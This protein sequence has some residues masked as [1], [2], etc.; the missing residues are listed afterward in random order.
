MVFPGERPLTRLGALCRDDR[1]VIM[2]MVALLLP[3]ILGFVGLGYEVGLWYQTKRSLQNSADAGA[4]AGAYE[5][6]AGG[7]LAAIRLASK[8]EAERDGYFDTADG[9]VI[10][11]TNPYNS[12]DYQVEVELSNQV[13]LLFSSFFM[14]SAV[15]INARAVAEVQVGDQEA[16]VLALNGGIRSSLAASGGI[17]VTM[18]GCSLAANSDFDPS[19]SASG[20][21]TITADCFY[22]PG[23]F[24]ESGGGTLDTTVCDSPQAGITIDDPYADM[25]EPT[26]A[27]CDADHTNYRL[28]AGGVE[29]IDPG[30]WCGGIDITGGS[31]LTM[32]PGLYILNEGHFSFSGGSSITAVG[33]S[34]VLMDSDG[35]NCGDIDFTGGSNVNMSAMTS[36]DFEGF[37]FYRHSSCRSTGGDQIFS[38]GSTATVVG[39]MYFPS[40]GIRF[41]GGSTTSG[42]C[43]QVVADTVDFTGDGTLGNDCDG[44]GVPSLYVGT[45]IVLIE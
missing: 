40:K 41:S 35:N 23:G 29:T 7:T 8:G 30:T 39:V 31:T 14:D 16:C 12:E 22:T 24:D 19:I 45:K 3:V 34:I 10:F 20:G 36:G 33:V 1:G 27:S 25:E 6:L 4:L 13:E 11:V 26:A 38:G 28:S 37:L 2:V 42:S 18:S 5:V 9:D 21:A 44:T 15:T 32:N 17:T 43:L